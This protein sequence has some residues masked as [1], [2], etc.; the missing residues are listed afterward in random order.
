[1]SG[2]PR[3]AVPVAAARHETL[4]FDL[5]RLTVVHGLPTHELWADPS[6]IPSE[7]HLPRRV[8]RAA[9]HPRTTGRLRLTDH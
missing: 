7:D 9:C 8:R 3:L 5:I 1:V 6:A 4:A 2:T